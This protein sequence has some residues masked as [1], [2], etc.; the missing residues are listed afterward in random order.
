MGFILVDNGGGDFELIPEATYIAT[1]VLMADIGTHTESFQGQDPKEVEKLYIG[2][3]LN[4]CGTEG[5]PYT[6]GTTYN[7]AFGKKAT[8]RKT[9][10]AW[11]GRAFTDEELRG[12]DIRK[13]LGK[14]CGLGVMHKSSAND[15]AVKYPRIASIQAL[16]GGVQPY[17]PSVEPW[18][19]SIN[20]FNQTDFDRLPSLAKT[21]CQKSHEYKALVASGIVAE[22]QA[23]PPQE[24]APWFDDHITEGDIPF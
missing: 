12:F 13:I 5:K 14:S 11:R 6:I 18:I 4:S 20:E 17:Q 15:P 22:D 21:V 16:P 19:F 23:A 2:W 3:E 8:L 7:A 9:L 1:C 24:D 10:E